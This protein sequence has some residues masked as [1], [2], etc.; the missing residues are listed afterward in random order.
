MR[1][2]IEIRLDGAQ[3]ALLRA[4]RI[5]LDRAAFSARH[6]SLFSFFHNQYR[7]YIPPAASHVAPAIHFRSRALSKLHT[8][9]A[10]QLNLRDRDSR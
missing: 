2:S 5:S 6:V 7:Y 3:L 10:S 8:A 9:R 4:S 1:D